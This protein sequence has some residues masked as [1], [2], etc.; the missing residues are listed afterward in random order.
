M[1]ERAV[2]HCRV[3]TTSG[4][5]PQSSINL[6]P[7]AGPV[8]SEHRAVL[9]LYWQVELTPTWPT[10]FRRHEYSFGTPIAV[11]THH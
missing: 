8:S 6:H 7:A 11:A 5:C 1:R 2:Q 3:L 10:S 4:P 9:A